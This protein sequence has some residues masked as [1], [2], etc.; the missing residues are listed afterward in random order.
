MMVNKLPCVVPTCTRTG[1]VHGFSWTG[2]AAPTTPWLCAKVSNL[3]AIC[4]ARRWS[5]A[6]RTVKSWDR[7]RYAF[8]YV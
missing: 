1:L 7:K 6:G 8:C 5:M 2:M 3:M 4:D